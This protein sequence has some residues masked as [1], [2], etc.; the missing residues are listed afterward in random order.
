M[1]TRILTMICGCLAA[2]SA[3]GAQPLPPG[4]G[5]FPTIDIGPV[6]PGPSLAIAL[7]A[8]PRGIN[9]DER[10]DEL[11]DEGRE[12]IEEGRYD[13]A[14]DRFTRLIALKSNRTDAALYWKAYSQAKLGQR[15]DA[16]STLADLQKQFA[17]SRWLKDARALEVELR[18]AS[19]QTVAPDSQNDEELKLMALRGIMQSDPDQAL[20]V[21]EKMLAG[22]NSPKVKDRALFV[23]SQSHSARAR[24]IIAGVAKG[25]GNPDLQLRAIRYL[26]IMGGTDNRQI[27]ADVYR[28][29]SDVAVKRAILRSYMTSNDRERLFALAK[30][31]TDVALRAEAVRQLGVMHASSELSQL[32]QSESSTDVKKSI[33]QAMF[34]GGDADKLIELARGE[35]DPELRKTAIRNLGL[36]K[37]ASTTEALTAIY[38]SDQSPDVRKAVINAL[39]LQQNGTALVTL[40]RAEKNPEMKKEIV[41]KLSVMPKSK[42]VTDYLLE[43]LK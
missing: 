26:G 20:P 7:N 40:A 19:G 25:T 3:A 42:E 34:V 30:G 38:A 17:D 1:T 31:E 4:A 43:L 8:G 6:G 36:M 15:A 28:S 32:Y 13:R 27:L 11:Y 18:Q 24:E 21:I 39:F 10:A 22:T 5:S 37:K 12:A 35:R 9:A 2:V 14:V 29:S 23:L 41:A 33:L 16:L